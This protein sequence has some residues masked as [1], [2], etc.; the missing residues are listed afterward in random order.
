[1]RNVEALT[2]GENDNKS[3]CIPD[4]GFCITGEISGNHLNIKE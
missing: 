1:M 4:A 2:A 3:N